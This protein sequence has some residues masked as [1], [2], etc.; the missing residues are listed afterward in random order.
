MPQCLNHLT[1]YEISGGCLSCQREREKNSVEPFYMWL[2]EKESPAKYFVDSNKIGKDVD[3]TLCQEC[4][5]NK[6]LYESSTRS[7]RWTYKAEDAIH[8]LTEWQAQDEKKRLIALWVDGDLRVC[9]H[10]FNC[11][12]APESPNVGIDP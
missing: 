4:Q 2:I 1:T 6:E 3:T 12:I 7:F 10:M 8:F 5:R 9:E 11:G